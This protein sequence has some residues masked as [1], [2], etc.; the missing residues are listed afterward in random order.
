[1]RLHLREVQRGAAGERPLGV[2]GRE[3]LLEAGPRGHAV[4]GQLREHG[5]DE[6]GGGA[7]EL[8]GHPDAGVRRLAARLDDDRRRVGAPWVPGAAGEEQEDE[9]PHRAAHCTAVAGTSSL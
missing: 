8:G 3:D 6:H 9:A 5:P 1:M 7:I 2:R 4:S